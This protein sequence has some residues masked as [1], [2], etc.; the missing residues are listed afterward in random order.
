MQQYFLVSSLDISLL[1]EKVSMLYELS[2]IYNHTVLK[3][4]LKKKCLNS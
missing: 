4:I 1:I 2:F 3:D